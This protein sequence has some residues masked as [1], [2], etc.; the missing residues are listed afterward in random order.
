MGDEADPNP[1]ALASTVTGLL[2]MYQEARTRG[3]D[4]TFIM[5]AKNG[6]ETLSFYL[7]R[8]SQTSSDAAADSLNGAQDDG[9]TG[10]VGN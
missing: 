8:S 4:V 9:L 2:Q 7:T 5:E 10:R 6:G 3:D 1:A